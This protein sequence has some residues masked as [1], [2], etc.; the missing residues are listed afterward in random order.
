MGSL[1][2]FETGH[3]ATM[4]GFLYFGS[5]SSSRNVLTA[6]CRNARLMNSAREIPIFAAAL[7]HKLISLEGTRRS[8]LQ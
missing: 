5:R 7:I 2:S 6:A 3:R 8:V 4:A 1:L